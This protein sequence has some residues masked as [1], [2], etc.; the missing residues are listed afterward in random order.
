M[1]TNRIASVALFVAALTMTVLAVRPLVARDF[2]YNDGPKD[3]SSI[4]ACTIYTSNCISDRL[5]DF[6][7]CVAIPGGT[8]TCQVSDVHT[9]R[10]AN[11]RTIGQCL[12]STLPDGKMCDWWDT[13]G[14]AYVSN[15]AEWGDD[16]KPCGTWECFKLIELFDTP[17]NGGRFCPL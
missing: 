1:K 7:T 6:E 9:M 14:C 10:L 5:P 15:Y 8:W 2:G 3:A 17:T 11:L 12:G 16:P 13:I 4:M